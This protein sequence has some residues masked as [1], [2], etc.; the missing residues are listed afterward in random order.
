VGE[1]VLA[2]HD[3]D[4][5]RQARHARTRASPTRQEGDRIMSALEETVMA[6]LADHGYLTPSQRTIGGIP[7]MSDREFIEYPLEDLSEGGC[8]NDLTK[9]EVL[10]ICS[11]GAGVPGWFILTRDGWIRRCRDHSCSPL[12]ARDRPR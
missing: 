4:Q 3:V 10:I 2:H 12:I 11:C 1:T 7:I 6:W 5:A 9:R 8:V